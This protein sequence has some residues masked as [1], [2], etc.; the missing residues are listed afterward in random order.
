MGYWVT[1][2]VISDYRT[3]EAIQETD[4]LRPDDT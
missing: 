3:G 1:G 4:H 2:N